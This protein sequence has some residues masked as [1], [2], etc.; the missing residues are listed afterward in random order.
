M[1][2]SN[3]GAE[4]A[5]FSANTDAI[6]GIEDGVGWFEV[7]EWSGIFVVFND[8]LAEYSVP[9]LFVAVFLTMV[10]VI[11]AGFGA[12]SV[13]RVPG[14]AGIAIFVVASAMALMTPIPNGMIILYMIFFVITLFG[15]KSVWNPQ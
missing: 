13:M 4:A 6:P 9:E 8:V 15:G 11:L 14:A 3:A 5:E 7:G 12:F 1:N 2:P 10:F